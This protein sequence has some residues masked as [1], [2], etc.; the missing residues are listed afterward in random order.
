MDNLIEH[1]KLSR[2]YQEVINEVGD[3]DGLEPYEIERAS[4]HEA[5]F[6]D[7]DGDT[8]NMFVKKFPEDLKSA[9]GS[10]PRDFDL[11]GNPV[12]DLGFAVNGSLRKAKDSTYGKLT[13]ILKTFVT[14]VQR[15]LDVIEKKY[16]DRKPILLVAAQSKRTDE[17]SDD[18]QKFR[19]Y[20]EIVMKHLPR[21]Y[22]TSVVEVLGKKVI[23]IQK[24][25]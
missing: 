9:L 2:L 12:F 22:R 5:S 17:Y 21:D 8:V 19:L 4:N 24:F 14:F 23:A 11:E 6:V 18:P 13:K 15:E 25:K 16:H 3:L 10:I 7:D 1:I 20:A